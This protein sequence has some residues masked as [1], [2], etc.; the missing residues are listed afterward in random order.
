VLGPSGV[1]CLD[2]RGWRQR[3]AIE[4]AQLRGQLAAG[5]LHCA[6]K[7]A[8]WAILALTAFQP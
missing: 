2:G 4:R 6:T 5:C 7:L 8:I 1:Q 3:C